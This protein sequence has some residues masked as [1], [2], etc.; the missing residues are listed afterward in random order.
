MPRL[1]RIGF[2]LVTL[3]YRLGDI[4]LDKDRGFRQIDFNR[5]MIILCPETPYSRA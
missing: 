3:A 1:F 4:L 2:F 5:I